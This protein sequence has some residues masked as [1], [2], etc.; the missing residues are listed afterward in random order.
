MSSSE[1]LSQCDDN[2]K[3][4]DSSTSKSEGNNS[5]P[6]IPRDQFKYFG[7]HVSNLLS[8]IAENLLETTFSDADLIQVCKIVEY[9]S[10]PV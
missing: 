5:S 3:K 8:L 1:E 4:S 7:V 6:T 9:A 2:A 10:Q